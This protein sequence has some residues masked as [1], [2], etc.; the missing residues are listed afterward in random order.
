MT[1][2][3]FAEI[4]TK[5]ANERVNIKIREF[6]KAIYQAF[7]KLSGEQYISKNSK[8]LQGLNF[9]ILAQMVEEEAIGF[10]VGWPRLL[11]EQ[12]EEK[13]KY[14]LLSMMDEM[15]KALLAPGPQEGDCTPAAE[16]EKRNKL[17]KESEEQN[18]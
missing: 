13:V 2:E 16:E 5:R 17:P 4:V 3:K 7:N 1:G 8:G 14:E 12:E 6:K 15:Q 10:N 11:W 9:A 18:V